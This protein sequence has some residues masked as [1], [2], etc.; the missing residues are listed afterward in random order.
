LQIIGIVGWKNSGKTTLIERL[1]AHFV[2]MHLRVSTIKHAHHDFD[3]DQEGK[4]SYRHRFAG[5]QE[6][7]VASSKRWALIH[8][9]RNED[10]PSLDDL[11]ARI[12]PVDLLLIEGFKDQHHK[13]IEVVFDLLVGEPLAVRDESVI[14]IATNIEL[15]LPVNVPVLSLDR[16]DQIAAFITNQSELSPGPRGR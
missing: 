5:A 16:V 6:V 2:G 10:E 1:V 14:A 8:E 12:S 7:L 13:K 15:P 9:L 11:I 4:D 3:I